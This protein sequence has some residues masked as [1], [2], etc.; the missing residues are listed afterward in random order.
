[1]DRHSIGP[2]E[3][4]RALALSVAERAGLGPRWARILAAFDGPPGDVARLPERIEA[5]L[6]DEVDADQAALFARRYRQVG[7]LLA[8]I[9][10]P[11]ARVLEPFL[12]ERA[13]GILE[14]PAPRALRIRALVDFVFAHASVA[15]HRDPGAPSVA[16]LVRSAALAPVAPGVAHATIQGRTVDGPVHLN[17]LRVASGV[18]I[19]AVD[20]RDSGDLVAAAAARAAPAAFSGGFFLYSEADIALPSVRGDPVGLLLGDGRVHGAPTFRRAALLQRDDGR[21]AVEVVGPCDAEW[22][23]GARAVRPASCNEPSGPGPRAFNRAFGTVS[24]PLAHAVAVE[25]G[26][27]VAAG[28]GALQVPLNG[29]VLEVPGPVAVG[30]PVEVGLTGL[31]AG[32][33]GGPRLL[34][35]RARDLASEDFAG[36]APPVTFSRDETFDTNRLPRLGVGVDGEGALWVVAVDGRDLAR[37]PGLTLEGTAEVLAA[38]GCAVGV[39]LD[40]GS[41]KRMVVQGRVV[42]L[43]STDLAAPSTG[44][45]PVRPVRTAVLVAVTAR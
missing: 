31:R 17:L 2:P 10:A 16:A 11:E 38:V 19:T 43:P 39:N 40:G 42:D 35:P 24:P 6:R 37:A 33:S 4:W 5:T 44:A 8:G 36:S 29:V 15:V 28:A 25:A 32:V 45:A 13:A 26:R 18:P 21:F 22:R 14:A 9:D 41:S 3:P 34:G 27:V 7:E 1:M 20:A 30:T 23:I 12:A